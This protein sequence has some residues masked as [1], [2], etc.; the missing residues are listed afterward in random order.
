MS[1][2][3]EEAMTPLERINA[4]MD[5]KVPDRVPIAPL[6]DTFPARAAGINLAEYLFDF[7]KFEKAFEETY[8]RLGKV[9]MID[10]APAGTMYMDPSPSMFST[11]YFEWYLPGRE[12][13]SNAMA[14]INEHSREAPIMDENGYDKLIEEGMYRFF[15]FARASLLDIA[16][17]PEIGMKSGMLKAK[18]MQKY[19]APPMIEGQIATPFDLLNKLRGTTNFLLDIHRRPE[20]IIEACDWMVDGLIAIGLNTIHMARAEYVLCGSVSL[21]ADFVSP[22]TFEKLGLPYLKKILYAVK[23]HVKRVQ[24]HFDTDW[25]PMLEYLRELPSR[26]CYLHLDERTDIFKAKEIL[27]DHMCLFGNLK[28]SLLSFGTP[29]DVE[30]QVKKIIDGCAEG[31]GLIVSAEVP[32]DAKFENVKAMVDAT[33]KYGVYRK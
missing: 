4:A 31:G 19:Q 7:D 5:L 24:C 32:D 26:N 10:V 11:F 9:D 18:W 27:G 20:K 28:P 30:K 22:K 17:L 16:K 14:E 13:S 12:R 33:K 2:Q 1:K 3:T 21:T 8:L 23:D 15:S 29:N 6:L 25:T